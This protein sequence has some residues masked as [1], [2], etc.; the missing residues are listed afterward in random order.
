MIFWIR[1]CAAVVLACA[2]YPPPVA[3]AEQWLKLTSSHFELFTTAGEKKGR[4][5]LLYFEQVRDFF[6][7]ARFG[8]NS[9][10]STPVRIIAFRSEKEFAPYRINDSAIA[11][12]LDGYDRDYIVMRSITEENYPVA[13][14]E[15]T[16]LLVK[17]SGFDPPV[18]FN[19]G[20]AE[21]YSTLKPMGKQVAVG[22]VNTNTYYFL[23]QNKWL[24]LDTL[25]AV[26][27][28]S[29]Y[30]NERNRTSI[31]YSESWALTHMLLLSP[32]YR[33]Q[34][35]KFVQSIAAGVSAS[36]ALWQTYAKTTAQV[37]KDLEQYM[38][39]TRFNAA[40]FDVQLEKSAEEPEVAPAPPIESG[41]VLADLLAFTDKKDLARQAYESLAKDFPKSWE[42]EAGLGEL[43][44]HIQK[45]EDART[46]LARAVELGTTDPRI[47]FDYAMVLREGNERNGGAAI[48][49]L[50][51]AIELDSG[52]QDAHR[53]LAYCL[54][55]NREYHE[56]IDQVKLVKTVKPEQAYSYYHSLAYAYF[57]IQKLDEAQKA[58]EGARKFARGAE[59]TATAEDMLRAVAS[60]RERLTSLTKQVAAVRPVN[61][62]A[63]SSGD[64]R[65]T[66]H[67]SG[68]P[69]EPRN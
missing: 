18:W 16:H 23:Q 31:F 19:E 51:R 50:K 42:P 26:D 40:M 67:R 32:A 62:P 17:H 61:Q 53:Y 5:A 9:L 45:P 47:Y 68:P 3:A 13:I 24:P 69:E 37:Q 28:K 52:Y 56:A 59:E 33:P 12:Y 7:K 60:E 58:G 49:P 27:R 29:P 15:F 34:H 65:P 64:G 10:P 4:E 8:S 1:R 57:Q 11:F 43:L 22:A 25:L 6:S 66:L 38:R 55:E 14:H 46:D 63:L 35:N 41:T 20:L 39:G 36:T 30:Y 2:L 54:L 44:W 48:A 21:V